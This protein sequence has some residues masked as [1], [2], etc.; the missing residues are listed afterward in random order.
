VHGLEP[1]PGSGGLGKLHRILDD[2]YEEI[3]A[4]GPAASTAGEHERCGCDDQAPVHG[5]AH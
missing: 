2:P 5:S 1:L 4:L 3:L